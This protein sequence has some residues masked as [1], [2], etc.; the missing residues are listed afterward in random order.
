MW[1][2]GLKESDTQ[3]CGFM[4]LTRSGLARFDIQNELHGEDTAGASP[5]VP[6]SRATEIFAI[7]GRK[8][9]AFVATVTT[10]YTLYRY[11]NRRH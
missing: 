6:S 8:L 5:T 10:L 3:P 4:Y 2:L 11:M 7:T 9:S 1:S